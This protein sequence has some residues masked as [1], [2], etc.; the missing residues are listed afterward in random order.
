MASL[1]R[2]RALHTSARA[3]S[4]DTRK[5]TSDFLARLTAGRNSGA[6]SAAS[7]NSAARSMIDSVGLR[8]VTDER[9]RPFLPGKVCN[10]CLSTL[11][12]DHPAAQLY[13]EGP[14]PRG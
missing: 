7:T 6:A 8:D 10:H 5:A 11:T 9:R 4:E 14:L 1:F 3:A 2:S 12:P 13:L